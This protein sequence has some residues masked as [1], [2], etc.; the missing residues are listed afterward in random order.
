MIRR[1]IA[2]DKRFNKASLDAQWLFLRMI[3]F[4]DDYGKLPGDPE[5]LRLFVI[6]G[7]KMMVE[8]IVK[9]LDELWT[10]DLIKMIPGKVI[11]F[12]G[13]RKNQKIGHRPADSIYPDI[14]GDGKKGSQSPEKG[15][16]NSNT[17][18]TKEVK[19]S[20]EKLISFELFWELYDKKREKIACEKIWYQLRDDEHEAIMRFIPKYIQAFP[21]SKYRKDP[22]RFLKKRSWEDDLPVG[23]ARTKFND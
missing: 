22:I 18:T 19:L 17:V 11:Q 9:L 7:S 21:N 4:A 10:I 15:D 3:P 13:W 20:K 8:R 1:K 14:I 12:C 6:P 16:N 23:R 2:Y 5:E